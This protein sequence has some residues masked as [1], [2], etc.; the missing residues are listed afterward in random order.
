M[1][2][3][4]YFSQTGSK[5]Y[6]LVELRHFLEEIFAERS[7]DHMNLEDISLYL[8]L[9]FRINHSMNYVLFLITGSKRSKYSTVSNDEWTRVSSRSSTR[10]FLP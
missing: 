3:W 2:F 9:I 1:Y 10:V 7:L 6:N 8:N 4:S 5:N